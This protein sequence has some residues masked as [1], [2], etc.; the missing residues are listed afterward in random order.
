MQQAKAFV[1]DL[2]QS[3]SGEGVIT[4]VSSLP[5]PLK[6][7]L[8]INFHF[9]EERCAAAMS[10]SLSELLTVQCVKIDPLSY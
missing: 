4:A 5:Q 10:M 1:L 8:K 7:P 9:C 6:E 3:T 2:L